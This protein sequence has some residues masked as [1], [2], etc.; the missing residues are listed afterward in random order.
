MKY[1]VVW[2]KVAENDLATIWLAAEDRN[3]I[4]QAAAILDR[5]LAR[6]PLILGESR[7]SSVHRVAFES[8]LGVEY[9]VIVDDVRVIV[10]GAFVAR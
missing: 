1:Q 4:A 7:S 5:D 9:E 3:A 6:A 10:H 2:K 8:P